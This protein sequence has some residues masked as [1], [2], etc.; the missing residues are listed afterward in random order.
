MERNFIDHIRIFCA[1]GA[2]GDG[3]AHMH[4]AKYLPKGDLP[5]PADFS[6]KDIRRALPPGLPVV[7]ISSVTGSGLNSLKKELWSALND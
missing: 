6:A 1:S 4:R 5:D 3:S 2:G 7:F